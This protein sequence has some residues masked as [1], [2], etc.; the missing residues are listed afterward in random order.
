M[1]PGKY[2]RTSNYYM[3]EI[4][5][6]PSSR[7]WCDGKEPRQ[8]ASDKE[9]LDIFRERLT[10]DQQGICDHS[11]SEDRPTPDELATRTPNKW[12]YFLSA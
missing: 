6:T 7:Q 8:K 4:F 5:L 10:Q 1:R 2:I 3:I 12:L 9:C 11:Y